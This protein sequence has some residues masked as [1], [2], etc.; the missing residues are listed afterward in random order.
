MRKFKI[1]FIIVF[2]VFSM[3]LFSQEKLEEKAKSLI[4]EMT[5]KLADAK[6]DPLT[7][8]QEKSLTVIY[9]R[10]LK[11]I[12]KIKKEVTDKTE[13]KEKIKELH[14]LYAKEMNVTVLTKEQRQALKEFKNKN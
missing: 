1:L 4:T 8:E 7:P 3:N 14:K 11:E 2:S 9:L 6:A 10:K 12:K 13:Q 5:V